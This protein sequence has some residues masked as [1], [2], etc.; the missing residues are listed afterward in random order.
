[1]KKLFFFITIFI[2]NSIYSQSCTSSFN[3]S[4]FNLAN[5]ATISGNEATLTLAQNGKKGMIWSDFKIDLDEDF[6]VEAD[7]FFGNT[8]GADGIAFVMQPLSNDA[9]GGGGGIGYRDIS[10]SIAIEFDT[11]HNGGVDPTTND[12]AAIIKDGNFSISNHSAFIPYSDLGN[13]ED[14]NYHRVIIDWDVS[15]QNF[16]MTFDGVLKLSAIIDIKNT[17]FSGNPEVYW[18]FTAATGGLNNIQK[19]KFISYCQTPFGCAGLPEISAG[20]NSIIEG[21]NTVLSSTATSSTFLWS[22]GSTESSLQVQPSITTTYTLAITKDGISCQ[23]S[24]LVNVLA[25][26]D[27]DGIPDSLDICPNTTIGESVDSNGCSQCQKDSD[28]DGVVNCIDNC[29]STFNLD[30]LDSDNDGTGNECDEDDDNDGFT[31]ENDSFSLDSTEWIDTDSD[32][33]GNNADPDDDNDGLT[34]DLEI[35]CNTDP[36]DPLIFPIDTD[37]DGIVDCLDLDDD[38]DGF[39]DDFEIQ[40][41]YDPLDPLSVPIDTDG[42]G[43]FDC[44]DPDDDNDG[45]TDEE[46]LTIGTDP[47][48]TDTDNDSFDD[49]PDAFP[50]DPDEWLDTDGDGEGDNSD[51]DA[52]NDGYLDEDEVICN[53]DPLN[54]GSLPLD[55]DGD[56]IPDCIDPDDDNDG[57]EDQ[58]DQL[59]LD[60]TICIDTDRDYV[61]NEIDLDDDNDGILDT[62]ETF[63]DYDVDGSSNLLDLDSDNDGCFDVLE[64]GF[65]DPDNNGIVG[66]SP[67]VVNEFGL[68]QGVLA[69]ESPTDENDNGTY[70]FLEYGYD[71]APIVSLPDQIV[72]QVNEPITFEINT[73]SSSNVTYQWQRSNNDGLSFGDLSNSSRF[74]GVNTNKLTLNDP[75]YPDSG[76][77][78]RV[79]LSPVAF[80]C[81]TEITSNATLLFY[82]ELFIPNAF[83]P[84]GDGVNDYWEILGLQNYPGSKLQIFNRLGIKLYETIDYQNDWEGIYN[85]NRLSD[86][87]YFY[88]LYLNEGGLE[89]GYVYIKRN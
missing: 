47:L 54:S 12:H 9:G 68:V 36:L 74:S 81:A 21:Q 77:L 71:F 28:G 61:D 37:A 39:D 89:K 16:S 87:V 2:V 40:C 64:A 23:K 43:I 88:Q 19:V 57:C 42:D 62:V 8:W 5:D 25:D 20:S 66:S 82:D 86:G 13:I 44:N 69:Y 79:K 55:Y 22:D 84:N 1:M 46:E 15:T 51:P 30:Q 78:F 4:D 24:I 50:L 83:S 59:P 56:F 85:G 33:I 45:L 72:Y 76:S 52:D 73:L 6:S 34:D 75:D 27:G 18:G 38:N 63:S 70:D 58:F 14:N 48:D 35:Q 49:L 65:E 7:L 3:L 67:V 17:I 29:L 32:G 41:G 80:A 26:S 60:E 10:P 31:D 11:Y 53:S